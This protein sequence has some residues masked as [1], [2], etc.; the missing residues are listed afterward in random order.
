M[1]NG[2]K[3]DHGSYFQGQICINCLSE[4]RGLRFEQIL[5]YIFHCR[6]CIG[7]QNRNNRICI[8][9][10]TPSQRDASYRKTRSSGAHRAGKKFNPSEPVP[11]ASSG[12][13]AATATA[14]AAATASAGGG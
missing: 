9:P 3:A 10:E 2:S 1:L 11:A 4:K 6:I 8:R 13:P 14:A 5:L 12:V 7:P